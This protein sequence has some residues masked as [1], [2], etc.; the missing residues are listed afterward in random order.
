MSVSNSRVA[1]LAGQWRDAEGVVHAVNRLLI[2]G[3]DI[4]LGRET[5]CETT[6][7]SPD[8][9][10]AYPAADAAD[11]DCMACLARGTPDGCR[12]W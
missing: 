3:P 6:F 5:A 2:A 7:W 1:T 10:A 9:P 12:G 8:E 4:D 11:V